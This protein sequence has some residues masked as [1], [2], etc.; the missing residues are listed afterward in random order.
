MPEK[1]GI[2]LERCALPE[3]SRCTGVTEG[4]R[5]TVACYQTSSHHTLHNELL[6]WRETYGSVWAIRREEYVTDAREGL[7]FLQITNDRVANFVLNGILLHSAALR[8][9]DSKRLIAPVEIT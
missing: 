8:T 5:T 3:Q 9:P 4:M 6:H 7:A 1:I 2:F